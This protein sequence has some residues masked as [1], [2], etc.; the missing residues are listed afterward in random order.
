LKQLTEA[1]AETKIRINSIHNF[2]PIPDDEPSAR[3]PSN[4]YR[5]SALDD[6]ER[7]K[8]I[9][10]TNKTIDLAV[11]VRASVVIIH[12]GTLEFADDPSGKLIDLYKQGKKD[13]PEFAQQREILKDA[14]AKNKK[15]YIDALKESLAKVMVYAQQKKIKI[16]L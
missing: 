11:K 8:A 16:G 5:L 2:C 9:E 14:R 3:H 7:R 4:Y 15:P 10:W 6:H 13:T 12:A 1:L